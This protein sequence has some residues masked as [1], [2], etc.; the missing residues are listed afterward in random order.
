M[1]GPNPRR[2][3]HLH[4]DGL[5]RPYRRKSDLARVHIDQEHLYH[6]RGRFRR[7]ECHVYLARYA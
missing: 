4:L 6:G 5:T 1:D 7:V 3:Y 2:R